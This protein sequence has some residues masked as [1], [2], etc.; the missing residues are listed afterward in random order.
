MTTISPKPAPRPLLADTPEGVTLDRVLLV[1]GAE[2]R[3]KRD[4]E[5]YLALTLSDR[6]GTVAAVLWEAERCMAPA[7]GTAV[8]VAG[9]VADHPRYG[10]RLTLTRLEPAEVDEVVWTELLDGPD[11]APEEL[12]H[13]LEVLI[14]SVDDPS[15]GELLRRLLGAGT[16]TGRRFWEVPAAKYHH[17][18]YPHGLLD[19]SVAVARTVSAAAA[20]TPGLDRDLAVTGALLHDVGKLEA[21]DVVGGCAELNDAGR[22]I[23]E[24]PLGFARVRDHIEAIEGFPP[25]RARALLHII[26]SH[27]GR[28]E[29]GSPVTPCTREA[30]LVHT[31]DELSGRMGAFDRL[32]KE[33]P[34]G[35]AWSRFDGVLEGAAFLGEGR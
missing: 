8:R 33:T 20:A 35:Q 6:S 15:L 13:D 11:R 2:R 17:H 26:L 7:A 5:P 32:E 22:L 16:E 23:G 29:H 18:A 12:E 28:L 21:Y 31:M 25:E 10:R 30:T 14:G 1:R 27:H 9:S 4:G 24:I 34:S 3:T 19:H